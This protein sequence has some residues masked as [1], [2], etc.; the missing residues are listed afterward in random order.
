M[1]QPLSIPEVVW[2]PVEFTWSRS[3]G[4]ATSRL[5]LA[6]MVPWASWGWLLLGPFLR[7]W[8]PQIEPLPPLGPSW[9]LCHLHG[10]FKRERPGAPWALAPQWTKQ[11][12]G[13]ES[14]WMEGNPDLE[15]RS[16]GVGK[17]KRFSHSFIISVDKAIVTHIYL[18]L[19]S[20]KSSYFT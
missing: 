15:N 9:L 12:Q 17:G 7:V 11:L 1:G 3:Y 8:M 18:P 5:A 2:E 13:V 6:V 16:A 19:L 4:K 14:A 10:C 20:E